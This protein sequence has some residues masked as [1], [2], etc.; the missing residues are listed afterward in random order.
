[1]ESPFRHA[2]RDRGPALLDR[3]R[4]ALD[5]A[6]FEALA[7]LYDE[8]AMLEE[9]SSLSPPS[10]P[11]VVRGRDAVVGRLRNEMLRDPV[12][13]WARQL[14]KIALLDGFETE[15]AIAFTEMRTYAAGDKVVA[16]HVAHKH[17]GRIDRDRM[18]IAWDAD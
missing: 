2:G 17:G 8:D 7:D 10:H 11:T 6:D 5:D 16:Q 14:E 18:V 13:G 12:S 3:I 4:R 1:M 9:I 15:D